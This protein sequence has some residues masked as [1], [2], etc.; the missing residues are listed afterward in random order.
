MRITQSMLVR[1]TI[2]RLF[3]S[4][5]NLMKTQERIS[6]QKKIQKPSDEPIAFSRTQRLHEAYRQN[7]VFLGNIEEAQGWMENTSSMLEQL[8]QYI[9]DARIAATHGTDAVSEDD[10]KKSLGSQLRGFLDEAVSLLNSSYLGKNVFAGTMTKKET[11][12]VKTDLDV[13]YN[14]NDGKIKRRISKNIVLDINVTGKEIVG[15]NLFGAMK[16]TILALEEGDDDSLKS[17]LDHLK[18]AEKKLLN[19]STRFGSKI[20]NL[21]LIKDRLIS[22]NDNFRKFIS[23]EEDA[24]LEEEIISLK[25]QQIA[26][27]AALQS[28]SEIMNLSILKYM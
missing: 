19:L 3:K 14:G 22:T 10:L 6:T 21:Q 26:Y 4:R 7:D 25:S 13:S 11:P 16:E 9:A 1:N 8:Y 20:S 23:Q 28:S 17:A 2:S 27:Q 15:T 18:D 5:E 12:F 24:V